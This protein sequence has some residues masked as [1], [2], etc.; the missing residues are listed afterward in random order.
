MT[1]SEAVLVLRE[2][3][4]MVWF[5]F[6]FIRDSSNIKVCQK[7][8][9]VMCTSEWG[10][11]VEQSWQ[12][13]AEQSTGGIRGEEMV[14][15]PACA[16]GWE[17]SCTDV[18]SV[19]RGGTEVNRPGHRPP[20]GLGAASPFG[21]PGCL[22]LLSQ[23]KG[24][25]LA[26]GQSRVSSGGRWTTLSQPVAPSQGPGNSWQTCQGKLAKQ[27]YGLLFAQWPIVD[28]SNICGVLT[29]PKRAAGR[30][31]LCQPELYLL[32]VDW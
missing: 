18:L 23:R 6:S 22:I 27:H 28:H 26:L 11:F 32:S 9:F 5:F 25:L 1:V 15:E 13:Q 30:L 14:S 17:F 19:P 29:V 16:A 4:P 20:A 3:R 31:R 12:I 24:E 10:E 2:R 21:T 7:S 8:A